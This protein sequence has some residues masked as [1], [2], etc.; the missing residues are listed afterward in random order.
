VTAGIS[1]RTGAGLA[2]LGGLTALR[3]AVS[4]RYRLY[5]RPGMG[6]WIGIAGVALGLLGAQ[7]LLKPPT[8]HTHSGHG[9]PRVALLLLAPVLVVFLVAP[10]SLG[11]FAAER[12]AQ[13]VA[14]RPEVDTAK[15]FSPLPAAEDG[16]VALSLTAY[17]DREWYEAGGTLDGVAIRLVG[18]VVPGDEPGTLLLTRFRIAC[19]AADAVPIQVLVR[20]VSDPLPRSDDWVAV[21]GRHQAGIVDGRPVIEAETITLTR[22]PAEPYE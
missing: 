1:E 16:A 10:P 20:G 21:V 18:F 3:L 13:R 5:V 4:G 11:S 22:P 6:L 14:P 15:A 12:A 17:T 2:V 7:R 9:L 19:C 8:S